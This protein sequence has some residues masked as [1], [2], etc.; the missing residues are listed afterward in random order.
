MKSNKTIVKDS[1]KIAFLVLSFFMSLLFARLALGGINVPFTGSNYPDVDSQT[2]FQYRGDVSG[3]GD[4]YDMSGENLL[5]YTE[6]NFNSWGAVS[7]VTIAD[8]VYKNPLTNTL[9]AS[10]ISENDENNLHFVSSVP[11]TSTANHI[12]TYSQYF[13]A[14]NRQWIEM[15][16]WADN[17]YSYFQLTGSGT[18]GTASAGLLDKRIDNLGGGWYR[19]SIKWKA[20][21]TG[22]D[23]VRF[24]P[25]SAD[26]TNAYQGLTQ[27]S[28]ITYGAQLVDNTD[29]IIIGPGIYKSCP[30]VTN[31]PR[32]DLTQNG[33]P[34]TGFSDLQMS[35]GNRMMGRS[36][37]GTDQW[38][39]RA[40]IDTL[41]TSKDF[42]LSFV[43]K[44]VDAP[45]GF[46]ILFHFGSGGAWFGVG[47]TVDAY[48]FYMPGGATA[49]VRSS[50]N[51][52]VG[53]YQ[54]VHVVREN[55]MLTVFVDGIQ[56]TPVD[57]TGMGTIATGNYYLGKHSG[58]FYF[59]GDILFAEFSSR[60]KPVRELTSD[61]E[62]WFGLYSNFFSPK[63]WI[64]SR[65][66][67]AFKDLASGPTSISTI[68]VNTP[69]VGGQSGKCYY[70][71]LPLTIGTNSS[72]DHIVPTSKNG[73]NEK[74][75]IC[76]SLY[77]INRMKLDK[78]KEYFIKLCKEVNNFVR[79]KN[80]KD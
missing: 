22:A 70:T 47:E 2:V 11:Y 41:D 8:N 66:T 68:N 58:G 7:R 50:T 59:H 18:V 29:G 34:T 56:G 77:A 71:G 33:N 25:A 9:T 55:N 43:A 15:L 12:Y 6:Q 65:S 52:V 54:Q 74:D 35:D 32:L 72:V 76:W 42:T 79:G 3:A 17:L 4:L 20:A 40:V 10:G 60:A 24:Y 63:A 38:Y 19:A 78:D 48:S 49:Y 37:N 1:M 14:S 27:E 67:P 13:K 62:K 45:A 64:F 61:R 26:N 28:I 21:A 31:K 44:V 36:L 51:M 69:R 80:E 23:L 5:I 30:S 39:N 53:Y 16:A 46:E 57:V 75:N 73:S